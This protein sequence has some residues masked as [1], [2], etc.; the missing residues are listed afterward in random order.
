VNR[1][2]VGHRIPLPER[3]AGEGVETNHGPSGGEVRGAANPANCI[4]CIDH[5]SE[6]LAVPPLHVVGIFVE[7]RR[8]ERDG[9]RGP[10]VCIGLLGECVPERA[11]HRPGE[12]VRMWVVKIPVPV[13][14]VLG[15][16]AGRVVCL[17]VRARLRRGVFV[18]GVGL[19]SDAAAVGDELLER[20]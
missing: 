14:G 13:W 11:H 1:L 15:R 16:R 18:V 5:D 10:S 4:V 8:L 17:L 19:V 7:S 12:D 2:D 20:T 3:H 6:P 9:R